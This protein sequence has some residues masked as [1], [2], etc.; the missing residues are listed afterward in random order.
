[1][2]LEVLRLALLKAEETYELLLALAFQPAYDAVH[3][4]P[5]AAEQ[6]SVVIRLRRALETAEREVGAC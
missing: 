3:M 2:R 5:T 4:P 1:M 6:W